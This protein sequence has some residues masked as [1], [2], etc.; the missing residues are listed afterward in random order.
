MKYSIYGA[1]AVIM[2][3]F[4]CKQSDSSSATG[5]NVQVLP[6]SEQYIL[7]NQSGVKDSLVQ[8]QRQ[9][10]L[11]ILEHRIKSSKPGMTNVLEKDV[12]H[13]EAFLSGDAVTFGIDLKGFWI[14]FQDNNKYAYGSFD[15]TLGTGRYVYSTENGNQLLLLDDDRR[16]KPQEFEVMYNNDSAA[17]VGQST[18]HDNNMQV[19]MNRKV[20]YPAVPA[21]VE[22]DGSED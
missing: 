3:F 18:Y 14:D 12:W 21:K 8:I 9:A 19:K 15:A 1:I 4:S 5:P 22:W 7:N 11:S 20:G 16:I 2:F 13:I 6:V 10:A 17:L